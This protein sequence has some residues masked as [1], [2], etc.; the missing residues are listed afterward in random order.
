MKDWLK[1]LH[2]WTGRKLYGR[3]WPPMLI[4]VLRPTPTV[5]EEEQRVF[6]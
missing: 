3:D 6:H 4:L 1:R 2:S 5:I